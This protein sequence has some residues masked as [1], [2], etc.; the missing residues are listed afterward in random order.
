MFNEDGTAITSADV[1]GFTI[2]VDGEQYD[3]TAVRPQDIAATFNWMQADGRAERAASSTAPVGGEGLT[4][5]PGLAAAAAATVSMEYIPLFT[6]GSGYGIPGLLHATRNLTID[7]QGSKT[8]FRI[9]W[10]AVVPK[11]QADRIAL[12]TLAGARNPGGP[13]RVHTSDGRGSQDPRL[14]ALL[15]LDY[16]V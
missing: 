6:M 8:S 2:S 1:T 12:A 16:D 7:V 9:G 13:F 11:S 3:N 5:H 15:P 10:R 4:D 14:V